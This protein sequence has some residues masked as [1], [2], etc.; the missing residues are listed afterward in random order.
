MNGLNF[1]DIL[2]LHSDW[3]QVA[4]VAFSRGLKKKPKDFVQVG[5]GQGVSEFHRCQYVIVFNPLHSQTNLR[6]PT[7]NSTRP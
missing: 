4:S 3:K 6:Q 2:A 7:A 5:Q 1:C